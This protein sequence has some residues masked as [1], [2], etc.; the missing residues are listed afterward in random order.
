MTPEGKVKDRIKKILNKYTP[1]WWFM[2]ATGGY[3]KSGVPDFVACVKG[4]FL[5]I[6][7]KATDTSPITELQKLAIV[8]IGDAEGYATVLHAGNVEVALPKTLYAMGA[9]LK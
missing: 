8:E 6:E 5:A 3:G 9:I 2:P 7:A 4:K 1:V